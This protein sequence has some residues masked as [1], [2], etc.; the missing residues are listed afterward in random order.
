VATPE[1]VAQWMLEELGRVKIL[2]Q[3]TAVFEIEKHFGVEH[4]Y[5]NDNGGTAISRKVLTE[6]RK[7]S[8]KDVV[9]DRAE[10]SWRFRS[11]GDDPSRNQT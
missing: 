1:E 5:T 6:F 4:T 8:E 10:R 7:L 11:V 9:W 3:E 2:E